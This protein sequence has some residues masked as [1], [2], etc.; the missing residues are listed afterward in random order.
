[1]RKSLQALAVLG[2]GL[3]AH[4]TT[5]TGTLTADNHYALYVGNASAS[6]LTYI[7]R[8][9]SGVA[10][11]P[12]TYNWSL[13]ETFSFNVNAGDYIYVAAWSD[14]QVAQGLIGQF[15][16]GSQ[17]LY[18]GTAG[19]QE[20]LTFHDLDDGAA[21]PTTAQL[22]GVLAGVTWSGISN[23]V[24]NGAGPWGTIPGINSQADWIWGNDLLN[25]SAYGEYQVFRTQYTPAVPE[26]GTLF[27]LGLGLLALVPVIRRRGLFG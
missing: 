1:M 5:I 16:D 6:T 11:S 27:L 19:W 2:L 12:G 20:Y 18:T 4:A 25:G 13:P 9:E 3:S 14:D 26:P 23:T 24:D 7:G 10:G 17:T 15:S 8:N 22:S 21:A